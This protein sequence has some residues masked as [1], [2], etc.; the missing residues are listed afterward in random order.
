MRPGQRADR[1]AEGT[2]ALPPIDAGRVLLVHGTELLH[3]ELD[4]PVQERVLAPDVRVQ[5]HRGQPDAFGHGTHLAGIIAGSD[6]APGASSRGCSTCT[7]SSAYTDTTKFVGIAPGATIVNVKVGAYDGSVDIT[8]IIAGIDW[9]VQHRND[10]GMNIRVLNLSFGTDSVQSAQV[11]PL[12]YAVEQAW[13]AGIVVVAA[14]GNDGDKPGPLAD[15]AVSPAVI[16]VGATDPH[17]TLKTSDDTVADF[18]QHG[19]RARP[20]DVAAPGVSVLSLAVP[21][22]FVDQNATTGKVGTRYQRA[23][24]TSQSTAVVSGLVALL[25]GKFPNSSPDAIKTLLTSTGVSIFD[26]GGKDASYLGAGLASVQSLASMLGILVN[27]LLRLVLPPHTDGVGTGSLEAARGTYHVFIDGAVLAGEADIFGQPWNPQTMAQLTRARSTWTGS[28]W[29][30]ST[31]AG[32]HWEGLV[33]AHQEWTGNDWTGARW[34]GARWTDG[35]W[36][37]A[38][39]SGAR[40]SGARWSGARWTDA[41]W[42]GA[43]WSGARWSGARWSDAGWD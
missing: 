4:E 13:N 41:G 26:N 7:G 37:G 11:D 21:G 35:V 19:T 1:P 33:W 8:Q 28:V 42:D 38:R 24:G 17:G 34:S 15:P 32:D 29:N 43:R 30:G 18:A 25:L 5:R 40:W 39:W 6:V 23:S 20:V 10:P 22:G 2:Q 16:A 14:G 12:V 31:W 27:G 3:L 9:V 36:D